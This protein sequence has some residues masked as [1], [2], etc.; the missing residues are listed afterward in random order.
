MISPVQATTNCSCVELRLLIPEIMAV[1]PRREASFHDKSSVTRETASGSLNSGILGGL[2]TP[3]AVAPPPPPMAEMEPLV[4]KPSLSG[5]G[6]PSTEAS[7][8]PG[9]AGRGRTRVISI[10]RWW[11]T[12]MIRP[13]SGKPLALWAASRWSI[14]AWISGM[15][16]G[17]AGE[18]SGTMLSIVG[19][20]VGV[21]LEGMS[22]LRVAP[23]LFFP[24]PSLP[25]YIFSPSARPTGL[26]RVQRAPRSH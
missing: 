2:R 4:E 26:A 11:H 6:L 19:V 13:E 15:L 14:C 10:G 3:A 16:G 21:C 20:G 12:W 8:P 17:S 7:P 22:C 5:L 9:C 18:G 24:L 23:F 25:L 1:W